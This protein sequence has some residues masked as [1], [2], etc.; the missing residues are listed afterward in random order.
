MEIINTIA[1]IS[2]NETLIVQLLS[3]L[4]FLFLIR[5]IMIRPLRGVIREREEFVAGVER[6]IDTAG[7]E[8]DRLAAE[9]R[10]QQES[11]RREA[12]ELGLRLEAEGQQQANLLF[13]RT[14]GSIQAQRQE[15]RQQVQGQIEAARR[16]IR[17]EAEGLAREMM[18][19]LLDR[20]LAP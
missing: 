12:R 2:I 10:G 16:S 8:F 20:R 19:K 3:F 6:E 4:V 11:V 17:Q 1:L 7:R 15:V 9:I 14:R 18:E 5:R 13:E